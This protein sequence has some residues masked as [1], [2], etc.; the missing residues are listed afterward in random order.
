MILQSLLNL[1]LLQITDL[2]NERLLF[3]EFLADSLLIDSV[4]L[5]PAMLN[6][7]FVRL[8]SEQNAPMLLPDPLFT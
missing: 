4:N 7:I 2:F 3:L 1:A 6:L 8:D 5:L